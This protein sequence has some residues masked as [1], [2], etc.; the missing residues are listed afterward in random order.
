MSLPSNHNSLMHLF[1]LK[2]TTRRGAAT[3]RTEISPKACLRKMSRSQSVTL[4][5]FVSSTWITTSLL[6]RAALI[7]KLHAL[8]FVS[9]SGNCQKRVEHND[10]Y[11]RNFHVV[12]ADGC[13]S[14]QK[15]VERL[16]F[17]CRYNKPNRGVGNKFDRAEILRKYENNV[18]TAARAVWRSEEGHQLLVFLLSTPSWGWM[19]LTHTD[20]RDE[21][22]LHE[23]WHN[24][25]N[26][27]KYIGTFF[28]TRSFF[29]G[30]APSSVTLRF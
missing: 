24:V 1:S 25:S 21:L 2:V 15:S 16:Y 3:W 17:N 8:E 5:L 19:R 30:A 18:Q 10:Q 27:I 6:R 13:W 14:F 28:Q 23:R 26:F 29:K 20:K 7:A 9:S 12:A 11:E 22:R 4:G